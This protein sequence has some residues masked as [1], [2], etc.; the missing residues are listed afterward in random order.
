MLRIGGRFG[1]KA[2][3]THIVGAVAEH[4]SPPFAAK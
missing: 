4:S 1:A 3:P 2:A